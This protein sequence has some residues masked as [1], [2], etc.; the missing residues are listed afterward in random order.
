VED[1]IIA[2]VVEVKS[3]DHILGN[4]HV[5]EAYTLN[6]DSSSLT[7]ESNPQSCSP[8]FTYSNPLETKNLAFLN[9]AVEGTAKGRVISHGHRT[10]M[11]WI[12]SLTRGLTTQKTST[13]KELLHFIHINTC[14]A[15]CLG[16]MFFTIAFIL[17][18]SRLDAI[19]FLIGIIVANVPEGLLETVMA[20]LTLT[21]KKWPLRTALSRTWKLWIH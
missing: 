18:Y 21:A 10:V 8:E 1:E 16:I 7:G 15:L 4:I 3:G 19:I 12:A 20:C 17:G 13:A 6:V 2:V 11:D 5:I 9:N 14:F